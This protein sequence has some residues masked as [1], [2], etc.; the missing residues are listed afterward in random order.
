MRIARNYRTR[1]DNTSYI[2]HVLLTP[3]LLLLIITNNYFYKKNY[4]S[5]FL[6]QLPN[7]L[8][9][10]LAASMQI[11]ITQKNIISDNNAETKSNT[12]FKIDCIS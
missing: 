1:G 12:L 10:I 7:D 9:S 4:Q 2:H 6:S 8:V 5:G 11:S 3:L